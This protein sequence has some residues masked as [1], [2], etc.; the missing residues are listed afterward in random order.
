VNN[1]NNKKEREREREKSKYKLLKTLETRNTTVEVKKA[2]E[3]Y[4]IRLVVNDESNKV[5]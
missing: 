4:K 3:N 5:Y 1:N 2:M